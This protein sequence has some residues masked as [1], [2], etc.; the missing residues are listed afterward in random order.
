MPVST[1]MWLS[2]HMISR[3]HFFISAGPVLLFFSSLVSCGGEAPAEQKKTPPVVEGYVV[4]PTHLDDLLEVSGTLLSQE[5]TVLM[6]EISGRITML[7][8]QEG[9]V[10][11]KGTLL[12]KMFDADL[13]AQSAK[14]KAQLSSAKQTAQRLKELYKVN[15]VSQQEYDLAETAVATLDAEI[16]L[17]AAQ[18]SKT[19]IRAPFTGVLGLRK[20]SEGAYVTVG[21][22]IA[23]LRQENQLKLDFSVPESYASSI[24]KSMK[25]TFTVSGD[26]TKHEATVI[27]TEQQVNQNT[28]NLQVR[29]TVNAQ[30]ARLV[31][32]SSAHVILQLGTTDS[33]LVIPSAAVIPDVR[34]KKVMV[35]RNGKV[36]Y[37]QVETGVRGSSEIEIVSGLKAGDTVVTSGIQFLRPGSAAKFSSIK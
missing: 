3:K 28:L 31:P 11:Q 35:V 34:F 18:I 9:A 13:Q 16:A 23:V 33:A 32:G 7:N 25:I 4:K 20:V 36:A 37:T 21:T 17:I 27:A 8:I 29:A 1:S 12:V 22:P 15:G 26:T 5:E 24:Q 19:E 2:L 30:S 14:L 6:P 10:V